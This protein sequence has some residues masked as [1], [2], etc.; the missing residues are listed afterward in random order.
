MSSR[1]ICRGYLVCSVLL[2][3]S[4]LGGS[5][6]LDRKGTPVIATVSSKREEIAVHDSPRGEWSRWFHV[7]L[8]FPHDD[9]ALG[10]SSVSVPR[11]RFD[12][13]RVGDRVAIRYL[14]ALPRYARTADR[15]TAQVL[16]ELGSEFAADSFLTPLLI[17]LAVG[18]AGLWLMAR[19]ATPAVFAAGTVWIAVAFPLLFPA[20]APIRLGPAETTARVDDVRLFTKSPERRFRCSGGQ[21]VDLGIRELAMPYQVV[22]FRFAMP[23]RPDSVLGAD[24]VDSAS[25]PAIRA[26][27]ILPVRYDPSAP[28]EARLS[29][30]AR[31]FRERNRYHLW[32]SVVG[33]GLLVMFG[34]ALYRARMIRK[35]EAR[36]SE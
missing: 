9:G 15:S 33:V 1:G 21:C 13:L 3:G 12:S 22:Q 8:E 36:R 5:V 23:G 31:T 7:G 28:R 2:A 14:P 30:G 20:P 27:A 29:L 11:E 10:T 32:V 18:A 34:A 17:W 24:A 26:G 16:R 35:D 4:L 6:W 25:I 19:I